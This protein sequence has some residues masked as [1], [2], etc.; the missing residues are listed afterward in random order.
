MAVIDIRG[1]H[2]S[3]KS[4]IMHYLLDTYP[5]TAVLG[6][7]YKGSK[8]E[9]DEAHIGY[10]LQLPKGKTGFLLGQYKN[11]CGGCDGIKTADEIVHRVR[12]RAPR[13][14]YVLLEGILVAHT[15]QRYS[16]L[17][18]EIGDYRFLILNT[19]RRTCVARV[20]A[21]RKRKGNNKPLDTYHLDHDH[22]RIWKRLRFTLAEEGHYVRVLDYRDPVPTVLEELKR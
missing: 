14:D 5:S 10:E 15:F 11:E 1:T 6:P 4:F 21:R 16:D 13:Y 12:S 8:H 7:A 22:E 19:P 20:R 9:T 17:A 18:H 3:G 2:G